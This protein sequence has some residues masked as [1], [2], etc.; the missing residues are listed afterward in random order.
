MIYLKIT[1]MTCGHCAKTVKKAL[2]SVPG[3]SKAKVYFPQGY[4]VVEGNK[5][6]DVETLIEAVRS[7]GYRAE[8][9]E[10]GSVYISSGDYYDM[11]ILGGGSAGFAAAIKAVELGAKKC[12]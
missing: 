12:L 6:L 7:S 5:A 4:A 2:E 3:V 8:P 10:K 9:L 1:G 11:F